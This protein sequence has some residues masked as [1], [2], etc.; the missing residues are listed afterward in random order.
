MRKSPSV[1]EMVN[2]RNAVK[3]LNDSDVV[4]SKKADSVRT[5]RDECLSLLNLSFSPEEIEAIAADGVGALEHGYAEGVQESLDLFAELLN[6]QSAPKAFKADHHRIIGAVSQKET[7]ETV[8]GPIVCYSLIH[9]KLFAV[10]SAIGSFDRAKI[11]G[12]L[13]VVSGA[14]KPSLAGADVFRFL[15][16]EVNGKGYSPS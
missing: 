16:D 3:I 13:E 8:F 11:E 10:L 14:E 5:V 7:G 1:K 12:Y 15:K 2:I 9:N 6:Y 4:I